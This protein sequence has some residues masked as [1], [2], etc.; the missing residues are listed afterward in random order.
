[1]VKASK[2]KKLLESFNS[3]EDIIVSIVNNMIILNKGNLIGAL[4]I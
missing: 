2:F 1:M 4:E 3:E